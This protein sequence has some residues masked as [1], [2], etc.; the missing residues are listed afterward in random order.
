MIRHYVPK[1]RFQRHVRVIKSDT[2]AGI[3]S[4]RA[5]SVDFSHVSCLMIFEE[6]YY[7]SDRLYS[8]CALACTPP[9]HGLKYADTLLHPSVLRNFFFLTF[10]KLKHFDG[11]SIF[12][13]QR[14][15]LKYLG[16]NAKLPNSCSLSFLSYQHDSSQAHVKYI[17]SGM[18]IWYVWNKMRRTW[19]LPNCIFVHK[20]IVTFGSEKGQSV[21]TESGHERHPKSKVDEIMCIL[22]L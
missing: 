7:S 11:K 20:S 3:S 2:I 1:I 18:L 8:F 16:S 17:V 12:V 15:G 14:F 13:R 22:T 10:L 5:V 4:A 6:R 19:G 9:L 21:D